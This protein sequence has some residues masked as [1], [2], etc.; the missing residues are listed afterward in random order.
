MSFIR[1][2]PN[3]IASSSSSGGGA[4][5]AQGPQGPSGTPNVNGFSAVLY[6]TIN[7]Y[8]PG[9][10]I[11]SWYTGFSTAFYNI[12]GCL[13]LASGIFTCPT[14]GYWT[15][16]YC[17]QT[18]AAAP[19]NRCYGLLDNIT[20]GYA[21]AS[22]DDTP[23]YGVGQAI[24]TETVA[25]ALGDQIALK[26]SGAD[27]TIIYGGSGLQTYWSA[28]MLEGTAGAQG[29]QG[30][31]GAQGATGSQGS[32]GAQGASGITGSQGAQGSGAQGATGATGAQGVQGP[33]VGA[34]G[35]QGPTG[36]QGPQGVGTQGPQGSSV[37]GAQG[38]QGPTGSQGSQGSA[39]SQ[40]LRG[41]QGAQGVAG[42]SGAA[43][44]QG[45]TGPQGSGSSGL[46]GPCFTKAGLHFVTDPWTTGA[47][48]IY[49]SINFCSSATWSADQVLGD[50]GL[51]SN[52]SV[53]AGTKTF[54]ITF[55]GGSLTCTQAGYYQISLQVC[56][57]NQNVIY[58]LINNQ[59]QR[60]I[61]SISFDGRNIASA[62]YSFQASS[63]D[64]M[65]IKCQKACTV[66]RFNGLDSRLFPFTWVSITLLATDL[67]PP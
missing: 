20:V 41:A 35:A 13:D 55:S 33:G 51:L 22:A 61:P 1:N 26:H 50:D 43:G 49:K 53:A 8:T 6:S 59:E 48:T 34:Q 12:D 23:G 4:Q 45:A 62:T 17:I 24:A 32:T 56:T 47:N 14:T 58:T 67:A 39:G 38:S 2:N 65:T 36:S 7:P 11:A 5:G 60:G 66:R 46:S 37:T 25:L 3:F 28:F 30:Q 42:S 21:F 40:G 57:N 10:T 18:N 64:V 9:S 19:V 44:A 27:G 15:F 52:W 54:G 31:R 16:S 29:I 63:G